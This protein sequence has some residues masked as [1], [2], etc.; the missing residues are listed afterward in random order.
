MAAYEKRSVNQ[1]IKVSLSLLSERIVL[2]LV[3]MR[4]ISDEKYHMPYQT[5]TCTDNL[6]FV[7]VN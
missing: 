5:Y 4:R 6:R 7:V 1:Y 2:F 3:V